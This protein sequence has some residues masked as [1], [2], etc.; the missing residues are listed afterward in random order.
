MASALAKVQD[1]AATA[2]ASE[3][4]VSNTPVDTGYYLS[5]GLRG[6]RHRIYIVVPAPFTKAIEEQAK[7]A[8]AGNAGQYMVFC[9]VN[10][11][12]S[13]IE[14][15]RDTDYNAFRFMY[16]NREKALIAKVNAGR[17]QQSAYAGFTTIILEK[18]IQMGPGREFLYLG[19]TTS[20]VP[21]GRKEGD[22]SF[23][24]GPLRPRK[25]SWPTL[26]I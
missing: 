18:T 5:Q 11:Q 21:S 22:S 14:S 25:D 10:Q 20:V 16:L 26:V 19:S 24:P 17:I 8:R 9:P 1:A 7:K 23:A 12:L 3:T 4:P 15:I 13:D 2:S 6:V